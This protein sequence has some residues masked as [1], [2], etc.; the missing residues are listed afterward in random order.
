DVLLVLAD[1]FHQLF[2]RK[3]IETREIDGPRFRVRLRVV[4]GELQANVP[5]SWCAGSVPSRLTIRFA[6]ARRRPAIPDHR[7]QSYPPPA[8]RS[9]ICRQ[10]SPYRQVGRARVE[11]GHRGRSDDSDCTP[12]K[13]S[14]SWWGFE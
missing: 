6:D 10:S 9:S 11:D 1:A 14:R 5:R 4:D 13:G 12:R 3:K 2:V 8:S 7:T